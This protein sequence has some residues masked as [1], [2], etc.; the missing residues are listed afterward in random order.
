MALGALINPALDSDTEIVADADATLAEFARL[1]AANA[2]AC[3][4]AEKNATAQSIEASIYQLS[5]TLK[6]RP[7]YSN[8]TIVDYTTFRALVRF[9]LYAPADWPALAAGIRGL[10]AGDAALIAAAQNQ[11]AAGLRDE[12]TVGIQCVDKDAP[13]RG[14]ATVDPLVPYFAEAEERSRIAGDVVAPLF[15]NCAAWPSRAKETVDRALFDR[16]RTRHPIL[17]VGNSFDPA[18]PLRSAVN[19]SSIFEDSV[20]LEHQGHG[21]RE[22]LSSRSPSPFFSA[23]DDL[24]D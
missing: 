4:L 8:G 14:T 19:S 2:A 22:V 7:V 12:S 20:V 11:P 21:V 5:D 3:P 1:C 6:Y 9:A 17:F 24:G 16:V 15:A 10:Q 23:T 18:T 13:H